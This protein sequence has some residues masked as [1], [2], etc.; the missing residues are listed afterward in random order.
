[1]KV[2]LGM[3]GGVD[4]SVAAQ[5]LLEAGYEVTGVTFRFWTECE[6]RTAAARRTCCSLADLR[7]AERLAG[8]LG[9]EHMVVDLRKEFHDLIVEPF[10]DA[11]MA[12]STPNPCV[13]C[14]RLLKFPGLIKM[15]D[16]LG[17]DHVATGHYARV[18]EESGRYRL[19]RGIDPAKDQSYV[20]YR[21][22]QPILA[23]VL[24]PV[25]AMRKSKV[26]ETARRLEMEPAEKEESQ[27]ICFL[28][29]G[30]YRGFLRERR[31]DAFLPGFILDR[32]GNIL[33]QHQGIADYTIGQRRGLGIAASHPY[34]VVELDPLRNAVVVGTR[35]EAEMA[36]VR[37]NRASWT[38]GT[39]PSDKFEATVKVRYQM[40]AVP[41]RVIVSEEDS[42]QVE[43]GEPV[44][45]AAPGQSA[46]LYLG[47]EVVGGGIILPGGW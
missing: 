28:P 25:G 41:G 43:L 19:L 7:D 24:F 31:P 27:D 9:V 6:A 3:S 34:Y 14:N 47:E 20:L 42:F 33:G 46:V 22:D 16:R 21:L 26:V 2:V 1:M 32:Q 8:R 35:E 38:A 39:P 15:A 44:P 40:E 12:G 10:I 37:A 13:E 18:A 5:L 23:R 45:A 29:D 30:D 11:Y 36:V 17:A 4:S